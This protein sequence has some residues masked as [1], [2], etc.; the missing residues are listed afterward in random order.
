MGLWQRGMAVQIVARQTDVLYHLHTYTRECLLHTLAAAVLECMLAFILHEFFSGKNSPLQMSGTRDM[1][2]PLTFP[3]TAKVCFWS[4][5]E[6]AAWDGLHSICQ[7]SGGDT[8]VPATFH[9]CPAGSCGERHHVT[10]GSG[11]PHLQPS[12]PH[13]QACS[14]AADWEQEQ[15]GAVQGSNL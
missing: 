2:T 9:H 5:C 11:I 1:H 14:R 6:A 15:T 4:S 13:G 10:C 7:Q 8:S 3:W 12:H